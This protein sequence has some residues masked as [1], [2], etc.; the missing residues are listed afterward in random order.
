MAEAR[1]LKAGRWRIYNGTD[2]Q[3]VRDPAT[4]LIVAFDSL[5]AA[6][7]W[8]AT[9]QPADPSLQEAIK[10]VKCGGYFSP[11]AAWTISGGR[12]YHLQHSRPTVPFGQHRA[13]R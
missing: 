8:W 3:V 13:A 11:S 5:E 9:L 7:R 10:C 2:L 1:K 12:Y 6:R 4:G